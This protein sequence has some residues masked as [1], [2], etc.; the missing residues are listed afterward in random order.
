[1]YIKK[2]ALVII[3]IFSIIMVS[4][5]KNSPVPSNNIAKNPVQ[6]DSAVYV[7][8]NVM[9]TQS[10]SVATYWRNGVAKALAD[11]ASNSY[12]Y[13]LATK[14]TD[15]YIAG[16]VNNTAAYWK[17][18]IATSLQRGSL[19]LGITLSGNDVYVAGVSNLN[20]TNVA[21]YWKNGLVTTLTDN[22][23]TSTAV[24]SAVNGNDVYVAGYLQ[25]PGNINTLCCWKN[26]VIQNISTAS[27]ST[28]G[29]SY[30][31]AISLAVVGTDEYITG[32]VENTTNTQVIAT[33]WKNGSLSALTTDGDHISSG[34]NAI[35]ASGSTIYIAGY[36]N[37]LA[38][39]WVNG[40][41]HELSNITQQYMATGIAVN[42]GNVYVS[43]LA[44]YGTTNAVYWKNGS[45]VTLSARNS[46]T[47]GIG[48]VHY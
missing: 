30:F 27:T 9:S 29:S 39:Y 12:A 26:G 48:I 45:L 21:T 38:A 42:N 10:V 32:A 4:C 40:N 34:A 17:N 31:G 47:G 41:I 1:M 24:S 13:A 8:G 6:H 2:I 28:F 18:G 7:S 3:A 35:T 11:S 15:V 5:K 22:L 43:G 36:D 19:A 37:N 16:V 23:T 44:G 20:G 25:A 14:D 46:T 33:Y